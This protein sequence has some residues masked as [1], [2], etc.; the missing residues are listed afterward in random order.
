MNDPVGAGIDPVDTVK[1]S[2][3]SVEVSA[4]ANGASMTTN[5][6]KMTSQRDFRIFCSEATIQEQARKLPSSQH[7]RNN[8]LA[9]AQTTELQ[10]PGKTFLGFGP[11][12]NMSSMHDSEK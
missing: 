9:G 5:R 11:G 10:N 7:K 3:P 6:I 1:L 2:V 4:E 12:G 8:D